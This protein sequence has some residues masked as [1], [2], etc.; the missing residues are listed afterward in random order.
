M[1]LSEPLFELFVRWGLGAEVPSW[2]GGIAGA[3]AQKAFSSQLLLLH[4]GEHVW[5]GFPSTL[6]EKQASVALLSK[7]YLRC[8]LFPRDSRPFQNA[9]VITWF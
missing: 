4:E 5:S 6:G 7:V 9:A 3:C 8:T 2:L 1:Q